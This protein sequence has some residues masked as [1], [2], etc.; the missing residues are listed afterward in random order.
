MSKISLNPINSRYGSTDA[1]NNNFSSIEEAI[2]NTLSR[3]G[4]GPNFM[5]TS[6]D[7]NSND[8]LNAGTV[9]MSSLVLG[10]IPVEPSTGLSRASFEQFSFT[11]TAG[12]TSFSV[13]PYTPSFDSVRVIVNGLQ[14]TPS[15]ISTN[16]SNVII[17]ACTLNDEVVVEVYTKEVS[18]SATVS[19][20][21]YVATLNQTTFTL[22][23][24]PLSTGSVVVYVNG[25]QLPPSDVSIS[26]SSLIIPPRLAGDEVVVQVYTRDVGSILANN[27]SY[28]S[29]D[30]LSRNLLTRLEEEFTNVK[31]FGAIGN[32]VTD[33]TA[34]IQRALNASS[35]LY[36]PP[37]DYLISSS[38]LKTG[39]NWAIRGAG[40]F[41][42]S[43]VCA[44]GTY[45]MLQL[46]TANTN[47]NFFLIENISFRSTVGTRSG[48]AFINGVGR[49]IDGVVRNVHFR[50]PH[51]AIKAIAPARVYF[52]SNRIESNGRTI[53]PGYAIDFYNDSLL[54]GA[55]AAKTTDVH[56]TDLQCR[57]NQSYE[58]NAGLRI[59]SLDGIY[60]SQ[61]HFIHTG[62]SVLFDPADGTYQDTC[63]SFQASNCYFDET[64]GSHVKWIGTATRAYRNFFFSNCQF[65]QTKGTAPSLH[66]NTTTTPVRRVLITGGTIRDCEYSAIYSENAGV[67][68]LIITGVHLSDNN[69]DDSATDGDI[70]GKF[71]SSLF[72]G[73]AIEGGGPSGYNIRYTAGSQ[74]NLVTG[75]NFSQATAG[76]RYSETGTNNFVTGCN[77]IA[78]ITRGTATINNPATSVTITHGA[79][80]RPN[81]ADITVTRT[82]TGAGVTHFW[83]TNITDTTFDV[84]TNATPTTSINFAWRV[85]TEMRD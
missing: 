44:D 81:S 59:N 45:D 13:A 53:R 54:S 48:G 37:G 61:C 76:I 56:I 78:T 55:L 52:V 39:S 33:D 12:Q 82:T 41:L 64:S 17:P 15:D 29:A 63:A 6:L 1:L 79:Y 85:D 24:I 26:G 8:I 2:E 47:V 70:Y 66:F 20:Y 5:E 67:D 23:S 72:T 14:L 7:M 51:C 27:I 65:R 9:N 25:L 34:A 46:G 10:G 75:C 28:M 11:A 69:M 32:G 84:F 38:L 43:I 40:I 83:V 80:R 3:D 58:F 22:S 50:N 74:D 68:T 18:A 30:N 60:L 31:D 36:F 71:V 49:L 57:G 35:N 42:T 73:C 4:T 21:Q 16:G 62:D 19:S 77:G